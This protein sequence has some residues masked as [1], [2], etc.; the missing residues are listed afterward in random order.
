MVQVSVVAAPV[1]AVQS[2]SMV[3]Q[4]L[5]HAAH[6]VQVSAA[7]IMVQ[8][9]ILQSAAAQLLQQATTLVPVSEAGIMVQAVMW[10]LQAA[11]SK[12]LI[13]EAISVSVPAAGQVTMVH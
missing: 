1:K 8:A 3:A 7:G 11:T 12:L 5:Q 6:M 9:A 4:L 13:W 2:I 10:L